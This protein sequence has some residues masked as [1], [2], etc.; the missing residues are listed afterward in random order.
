MR[1]RTRHMTM[2]QKKNPLIC[3]RREISFKSFPLIMKCCY[4]A[5]LL[6]L[7]EVINRIITP[8]QDFPTMTQVVV[9]L[10]WP[11]TTPFSDWHQKLCWCSLEKSHM[12]YRYERFHRKISCIWQG[13]K[14]SVTLQ[15]WSFRE[16]ISMHC[17]FSRGLGF[18]FFSD[19]THRQAYYLR[20][21]NVNMLLKCYVSLFLWC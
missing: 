14:L 3:D 5:L 9:D 21:G 18:S 4:S 8:S 1:G 15:V 20:F 16:I 13:V 12:L 10:S 19:Q 7:D 17:Y 6:S 2:S 11:S